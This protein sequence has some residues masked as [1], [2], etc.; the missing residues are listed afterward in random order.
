MWQPISQ[1]DEIETNVIMPQMGESNIEG[2]VTKWLKKVGDQIRRDEPLFEISTDKVDAEIPAPASGVLREIR[3]KQ[4]DTVPANNVVAVIGRAATSDEREEKHQRQVAQ[5]EHKD[6]IDRLEALAGSCGSPAVEMIRATKALHGGDFGVMTA[7]ALVS[8]DARHILGSIAFAA[9]TVPDAALRLGYC[10]C[11]R[12]QPEVHSWI[13]VRLQEQEE[14]KNQIIDRLYAEHR[15][16]SLPLTVALLSAYDKAQGTTLAGQAA[17]TYMALVI[18][19]SKCCSD[20]VAARLVAEHFASLLNKYASG[21]SSGEHYSRASGASEPREQ[22]NA[23]CQ[24]C[25]S[26]YRILEVHSDA[27]VETIRQAYKDLVNVWHP[28]RFGHNEGLRQRAE[29]RFKGIQQAYSHVMAHFEQ[30]AR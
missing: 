8:K 29:E 28:D 1:P 26:F 20:S 25:V 19:A 30:T 24:K 7:T 5:T 23:G 13:R 27:S 12:L 22:A 16:A 14:Y 17:S 18:A 15:S 9:G 3:A 2:T 4:G 11:S 21:G 6:L 10:I